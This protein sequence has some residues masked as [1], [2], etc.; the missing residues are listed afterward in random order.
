M[1]SLKHVRGGRDAAAFGVIR[2]D[3]ALE[4]Q[5]VPCLKDNY[6]YLLHE[7]VSGETAAVDP[8]EA[9]P[10]L[11]A[12]RAR[13]WR[14]SHVLNT[15]HHHDHTGGNLAL[16]QATGARIV[17]PAADRER[18]PGIDLALEEDEVFRL[19]DRAGMVMFIPGHTRGHIAF[20]F[21]DDQAVFCGDTLFALGCGRMFEGTAP[22]MWDSLKK[23]RCL[24]GP[25]RVYCGHEYT[26][27]NAR[28][29]LT[30][31]PGNAALVRRAAG[32]DTTRAAGKPTIPSTMAEE[33]ATNPFLRADDPATAAAAGLPGADPVEVF[34]AI[35]ARKDKF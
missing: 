27:A 15:H 2:S 4:I 5:L 11:A 30:V 29:A 35:R 32:I 25:T 17:G 3:M 21:A 33:C 34:A 14:L 18:I 16:R 8:S 12:A 1:P 6:A 10:V 7:P 22:Q 13:G 26:Q 31:E 20:H 23:L 19:G 28:F 24:P 9:E